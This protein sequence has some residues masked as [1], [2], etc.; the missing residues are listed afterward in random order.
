M[1]RLNLFIISLLALA[2]CQETELSDFQDKAVV[3]AYLFEG[4]IPSVKVSK[5]IP[6]TDNAIFSDMDIEKLSI[7][8]SEKSTGKIYLLNSL[9]SGK[10]ENSELHITAGETYHIYF[11][12]NGEIVEATTTVPQKPQNVKISPTSITVYQPGDMGGM[13]S[14]PNPG[15]QSKITIKWENSDKSYYLIVVQNMETSP[16]AIYDED[17]DDRPSMNF[18][19]EP[20]LLDS[21]DISPMTFQYYGRHRVLL[22]KIQPEYALLY[23]NNSN[24]SQSLLEIHANIING[25]GIFT[26]INT[27]TMYVRVQK[28]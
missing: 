9:G 17:E 24:S 14:G 6:F 7:R 23:S 27:D 22:S 18:R 10:Y 21:C 4:R 3:E 8:I 20:T 19:S 11:P 1:N 25:F 2:S 5:L 15:M 26:A 16:V 13:G 28:P 12:Y